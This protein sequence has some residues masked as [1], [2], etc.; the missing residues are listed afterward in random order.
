MGCFALALFSSPSSYEKSSKQQQE[1]STRW[2]SELHEIIFA[3]QHMAV[4]ETTI[5]WYLKIACFCRLGPNCVPEEQLGGVPSQWVPN[6]QKAFLKKKRGFV[7]RTLLFVS[8]RFVQSSET[9]V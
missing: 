7:F 2:C 8:G 5:V 4:S 1:G 9:I 6:K 3:T